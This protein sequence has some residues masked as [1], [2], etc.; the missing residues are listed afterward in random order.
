MRKKRKSCKSI[1]DDEILENY[2]KKPLELRLEWLF[3]GNVLRK[4][5]SKTIK[6]LQQKFRK[7]TV[8]K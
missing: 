7:S 2:R 1:L 5:C 8:V 3:I 4:S 6:L